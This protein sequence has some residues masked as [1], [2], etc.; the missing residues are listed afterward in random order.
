MLFVIWGVY[1]MFIFCFVLIV[2]YEVFVVEF[3]GINVGF[4]INVV[5]Y[6]LLVEVDFW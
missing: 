5:F 4:V 3:F 6:V 1:V 2:V